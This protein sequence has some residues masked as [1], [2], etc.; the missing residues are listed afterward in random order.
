MLLHIKTDKQKIMPE[1]EL[2][3]PLFSREERL[4]ATLDTKYA[5]SETTID[6]HQEMPVYALPRDIY[7]VILSYINFSIVDHIFFREQQSSTLSS[8]LPTHPRTSFLK[9]VRQELQL[10]EKLMNTMESYRQTH[11]ALALLLPRQVNAIDMDVIEAIAENQQQLAD[12]QKAK[13]SF[14]SA[15]SRDGVSF[16]VCSACAV[17]S[18]F[19]LLLFPAALLAALTDFSEAGMFVAAM[20]LCAEVSVV[21]GV[22]M[23]SKRQKQVIMD[24]HTNTAWEIVSA[25]DTKQ[26]LRP[27]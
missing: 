14:V 2:Q 12:L 8:L 19:M 25:A 13:R 23:L 7:L 11:S 15:E 21:I 10:D 1:I 20:L 27:A 24:A 3:E 9:V 26:F 6:I 16:D 4:N 5:L 17:F 18:C 22:C